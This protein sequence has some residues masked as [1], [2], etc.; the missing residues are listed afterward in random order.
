MPAFPA[1]GI[2]WLVRYLLYTPEVATLSFAS[3]GTAARLINENASYNP[4]VETAKQ[5][6]VGFREFFDE[7]NRMAG[8][9]ELEYND[10]KTYEIALQKMT[11]HEIIRYRR[12]CNVGQNL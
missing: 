11:S 7:Y 2:G 8:L 10:Q 9:L 3:V 12:F 6:Q 1:F 4:N 5:E